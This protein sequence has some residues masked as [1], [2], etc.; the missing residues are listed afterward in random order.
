MQSTL[1]TPKSNDLTG[2][3]PATAFADA[4]AKM[5]GQN[6][7]GPYRAN[8]TPRIAQAIFQCTYPND[9]PPEYKN[10]DSLRFLG[11]EVTV[12]E[13]YLDRPATNALNAPE[14]YM[15]PFAVSNN[16]GMGA[17]LQ[18]EFTPRV[19]VGVQRVHDV[20]MPAY[21]HDGDS[22][23]DLRSTF[24]ATLTLQPG[25]RETVPTGLCFSLPKGYEIQVR[26]RSGSAHKEG[27]TVLNSPGTIDSNYTGE[28]GV[29]LINHGHEAITINYLDR[30]AQ[31]VLCEVPTATFIE[32]D[33]LAPTN[34]GQGGF[35]STGR[36]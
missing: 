14:K 18:Y 34:R 12:V 9:L 36:S 26:P 13:D 20:P 31:G 16:G 7:N 1:I 4:I 25:Q 24:E 11:V 27:L 15:E 22:G 32:I 29:I 17:P 8:V 23:F 33:E 6:I 35:G 19:P 2:F 3:D 28:V 30:I 10:G 21:K 5:Q